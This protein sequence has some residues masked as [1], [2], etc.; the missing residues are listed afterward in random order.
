[1]Y[2]RTG[3]VLI[4]SLYITRLV[5]K[6]LGEFDYGIYSLIGS[7]VVLFTFINSSITQA[8]QRF[9]TIEIGKNNIE[10]ATKVFSTSILIQV[11]LGIIFIFLCETVGLYLILNV[12]NVGNRTFAALWVFQF[13]ILAFLINIF[14]V[15]LEATV[16]AY[17]KLSFY[18][19][20]SV[21]E[22]VFKLIICFLLLYFHDKLIAYSGLLVLV[23]AFSL[24]IYY[25]YCK[26]NFELCK[27]KLSYDK[28]LFKQMLFF[29]GWSMSGSVTNI[30]TQSLFGVML[31][32]FYGVLLNTALGIANQINAALSQFI[33]NFQTSFR[34]QIIKAFAQD[35]I[36][37]FKKLVC[38]TSKISFLLA[39][40]P[41]T[42]LIFN[43]P[44]ILQIWLGE[45]P[46]YT[47]TF[48]RFIVICALFDA[49]TGPYYCSLTASG[50]I[51]FYQIYISISFIIDIVISWLIMNL[52]IDPIYILLPRLITRGIINM[53]IGLYFMNKTFGFNIKKYLTTIIKPLI[54]FTSLLYTVESILISY[55]DGWELIIISTLGMI[56][57]MILFSSYLLSKAEKLQI[58]SILYKLLRR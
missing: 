1:M 41:S 49:L 34:P 32:F 19:V 13:S 9:L 11:C 37:Y 28:T 54:I 55:I 48:C 6:Q 12:L 51:K 3:I 56:L 5:L 25:I 22:A 42:I 53:I 8:I 7:V 44:F 23:S 33:S 46:D 20:V 43:M 38:S 14:K 10:N 45:Y 17:E 30:G 16:I 21:V 40:I 36:I 52:H 31:N 29:S 58:K 18:A 26:R 27:F 47:V 39:L 50:K 4:L 35:D 57:L 24:F 2:I 15:P